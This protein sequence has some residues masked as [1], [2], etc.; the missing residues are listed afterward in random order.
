MKTSAKLLTLLVALSA[1]VFTGCEKDEDETPA[2]N[3]T[4]NEFN[5]SDSYGVFVAVK[6]VTT[7]SMGGITIPIE[8]NTATAVFMSSAGNNTF[9]EAGEVKL[10][11][12]SLKKYQ[13]NAYVYDDLVNPLDFSSVSW[14]ASGKGDVPAINKVVTK[15]FPAFSNADNIPAS[16]SLAEGFSISLGSQISKADSV[17]VVVGGN[18]KSV[19]KTVGGNAASVSFSSADLNNIGT[20]SAGLISVTPY[21]FT[22]ETIASKRY[23][24]INETVYNKANVNIIR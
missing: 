3:P 13:N 22:T 14:S 21:N 23:Y 1:L 17:I 11:N 4:A 2:E 20:T 6:S 7:Q 19:Y 15:G 16:I 18:N 9:V 8:V 24:F 5:F 12:K 10:N